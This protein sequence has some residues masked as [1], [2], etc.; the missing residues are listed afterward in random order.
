MPRSF[1]K[2]DIS[3][4]NMVEANKAWEKS[5]AGK[6][7]VIAVIDSGVDPYHEAMKLSDPNSGRIK[8]QG[9]VKKLI[10]DLDIARGEYFSSKIPFGY[11]YA[12]KS[13][14]I[15]EFD[16]MSH[17]MHVSGIVAGNSKNSR[18]GAGS[19]NRVYARLWRRRLRKRHFG[20][21]LYQGH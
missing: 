6:G 15:K 16:P 3:S 5:Y 19:T 11:N 7:S 2:T 20:G 9:E 1:G 13:T 18:C 10:D 21:N 12:N 17:G 14:S 8:S 4:N